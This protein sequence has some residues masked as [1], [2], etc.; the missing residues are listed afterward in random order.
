MT[1][2][3]VGWDMWHNQPAEKP[4]LF[5]KGH[6]FSPSVEE[7]GRKTLHGHMI[8]WIEGHRKSQK[9]LFFGNKNLKKNAPGE[10]IKF[11]DHCAMTELFK[12]SAMWCSKAFDHKGCTVSSW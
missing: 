6:A 4:G 3:V 1:E 11:C 5:G 9:D 10:F 12:G 8:L 2:E 7:Q